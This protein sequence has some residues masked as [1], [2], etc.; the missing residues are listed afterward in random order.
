MMLFFG[1]NECY[2]KLIEENL[3]VIIYVRIECV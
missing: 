2:L 1:S 3:D